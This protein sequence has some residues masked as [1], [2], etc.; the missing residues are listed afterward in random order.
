MI[1][2]APV[3][4]QILLTLIVLVLLGRARVAA[5]KAGKVRL[6]EIAVSSTGW[7]ED[8]RRI[9]ANVSNQF[10]TPV[11]FYVLCGVTVFTGA[12]NLFTAVCA[13]LYV[14]SRLAHWLV[15]TGS[16][17]VITRFRIFHFGLVALLAMWL[18][19]VVHLVIR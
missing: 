1:L 5:V 14:A 19:V 18:Y 16:N 4:A 13:W 10:E 6:S 12:A 3:L 17:N 8:V 15:H 11:L 2:V 7:P 9:Q